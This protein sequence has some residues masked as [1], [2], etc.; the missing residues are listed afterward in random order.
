MVL[1]RNHRQ[2]KVGPSVRRTSLLLY[3]PRVVGRRLAGL[4]KAAPHVAWWKHVAQVN[5]VLTVDVEVAKERYLVQ[6]P[7]VWAGHL[8]AM[9]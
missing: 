5:E 4:R 6:Y 3:N 9:E 7:Q 1:A 8:S 2:F